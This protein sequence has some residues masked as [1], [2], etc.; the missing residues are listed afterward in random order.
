M[1][2]CSRCHE[3]TEN[4][5]QIDRECLCWKCFKMQDM[6]DQRDWEDDPISESEE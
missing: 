2:C 6:K 3:E 1:A 4:I 5:F